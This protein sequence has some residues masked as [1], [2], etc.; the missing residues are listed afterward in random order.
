MKGPTGSVLEVL[1]VPGVGSFESI[2]WGVPRD[3]AW[4]GVNRVFREERLVQTALR[5]EKGQRQNR[6]FWRC[7]KGFLARHLWNR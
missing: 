2:P 4:C 5:K 6:R 3:E 1:D 7:Q